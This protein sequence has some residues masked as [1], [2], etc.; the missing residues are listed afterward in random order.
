[1]GTLFAKSPVSN[2]MK[3][4]NPF[5]GYALEEEPVEWREMRENLHTN[6]DDQFFLLRSG[7]VDGISFGN[8]SN[9]T[10]YLYGGENGD[11]LLYQTTITTSSINL[12]NYFLL[13]D[14]QGKK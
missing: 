9:H 1:M 12:R 8:C 13:S 10:L 5:I 3:K 6:P 7:A 2:E 11:T 14:L 4:V